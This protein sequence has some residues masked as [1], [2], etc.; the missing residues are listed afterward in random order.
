MSCCTW[1]MR[2]KSRPQQSDSVRNKTASILSATNQCWVSRTRAF[3]RQRNKIS[4]FGWIPDG[5]FCRI[6]FHKQQEN[7]NRTTIWMKE[8]SSGSQQFYYR[9]DSTESTNPAIIFIVRSCP[10]YPR[11]LPRTS[12]N[13]LQ[14]G[15]RCSTLLNLSISIAINIQIRVDTLQVSQ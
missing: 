15:Y 12:I 8:R 4:S 9:T 13:A 10:Q 1:R 2:L 5:N 14:S 3:N 6:C 11:V 7:T